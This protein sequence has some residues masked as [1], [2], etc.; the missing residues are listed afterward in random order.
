MIPQKTLGNAG[1]K[2]SKRVFFFF[3]RSHW[4]WS[5][6]DTLASVSIFNQSIFSQILNQGQR[7]NELKR[8]GERTKIENEDS[9]RFLSNLYKSEKILVAK[10]E[11][12]LV[13]Q[14]PPSSKGGY[15]GV[16]E[17][18]PPIPDSL[19]RILATIRV[20]SFPITPQIFSKTFLAEDKLQ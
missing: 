15:G 13:E 16:V 17:L 3:S 12:L 14:E 20:N 6:S 2:C 4:S 10:I 5:S 1:N 11:V 18:V 9:P 19:K 8:S 7:T